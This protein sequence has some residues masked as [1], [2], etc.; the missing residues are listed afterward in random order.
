M[1]KT[2]E[3][4]LREPFRIKKEIPL[5]PG[6]IMCVAWVVFTVM[7]VGWVMLASLSTSREILGGQLFE[8]A[9]G[10]H[11]ENYSNAWSSQKVGVF[12]VNSLIYTA[13]SCTVIIVVASPA[14]YVLSRFRFRGEHSPAEHVRHRAGHPGHHDHHAS[15]LGHHQPE[16]DQHPGPDHLPVH[17]DERSVHHLLYAFFLPES[18]LHL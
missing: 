4:K 16:T 2:K 14:A 10:F 3:K 7:L 1:A 12:F 8:F 13:I 5:L 6:Y 17:C 11:W 9:S 15:V 18:L